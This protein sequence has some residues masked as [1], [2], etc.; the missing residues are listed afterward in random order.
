MCRN[1]ES[2]GL[3]L[4]TV[5]SHHRYVDGRT[6]LPYGTQNVVDRMLLEL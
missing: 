5:M 3:N 1:D 4:S 2:S 6:H